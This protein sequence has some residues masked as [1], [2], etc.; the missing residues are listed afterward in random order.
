MVYNRRAAPVD[1]R[2]G[3]W[4]LVKFPQDESGKACKLSRPWHGPYR[5]L[6][7]KD[8]LAKVLF[9]QDGQIH[10]HQ[11]RVKQCP[12]GFPGE[13]YWYGEK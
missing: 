9:P 12:I 5:V 2:V 10:V 3:D 13:Y 7:R 11:H 8:P 1:F 4:V 6:S